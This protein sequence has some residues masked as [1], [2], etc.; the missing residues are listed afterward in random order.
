MW[1]SWLSFLILQAALASCTTCLLFHYI[2]SSL[3]PATSILSIFFTLYL[4]KP[5]GKSRGTI[6]ALRSMLSSALRN[7]IKQLCVF[8][9]LLFR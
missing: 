5:G 3:M 9:T 4:Y 6:L 7:S 8:S 1:Y 2:N